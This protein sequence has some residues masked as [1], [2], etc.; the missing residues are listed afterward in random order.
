M[1][2]YRSGSCFLYFDQKAIGH[3]MDTQQTN[4]LQE[5]PNHHEDGHTTAV[6]L[7]LNPTHTNCP[8]PRLTNFFIFLVFLFNIKK[9]S[10]KIDSK[11]PVGFRLYSNPRFPTPQMKTLNIAQNHPGSLMKWR[12]FKI[13]SVQ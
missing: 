2:Y 12:K 11:S 10:L 6:G 4:R 8:F 9:I 13:I 7:L 5:S 1:L 3:A